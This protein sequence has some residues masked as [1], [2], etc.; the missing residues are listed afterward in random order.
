MNDIP[1]E[2]YPTVIRQMIV[3]EDDVTHHRLLWLLV[4]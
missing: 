2:Q 3:H 4:V 1:Q